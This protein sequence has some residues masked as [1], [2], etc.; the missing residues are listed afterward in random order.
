M[1]IICDNEILRRL[2]DLEENIYFKISN[3]YDPWFEERKFSRW[4][5]KLNRFFSWLLEWILMSIPL[6]T[7][8][9]FVRTY[10]RWKDG[11]QTWEEEKY[12]LLPLELP[13]PE[14]VL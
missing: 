3:I 13:E 11:L 5:K 9:E 7:V 14:E 4:R 8:L 2:D 1:C 12:V 6:F 10:V